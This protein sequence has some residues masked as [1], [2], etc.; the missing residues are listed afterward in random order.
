MKT[1]V[2]GKY[3]DI[4]EWPGVKAPNGYLWWPDY[5]EK[6]TFEQYPGL[7]DPGSGPGAPW[8][9]VPPPTSRPSRPGRRPGWPGP[10]SGA[11][12]RE[13]RPSCPTICSATPCS[14]PTAS[15]Y[16]ITAEKTAAAH[17]QNHERHPGGPRPASPYSLTWN[18]TGQECQ[19]W[20]LENLTALAFAIDRPGH[21]PC[22]LP[23][24]PGGGHCGKRLPWRPWRPSRWTMIP[25]PLPGGETA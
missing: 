5:L 6:D 9:A 17:R 8:S 21:Q 12:R 19:A 11:N 16:A 23:T 15:I 24:G 14:G 1:P 25:V 18:A 4:V 3:Q 20:T 13:Q 2:D 10:E 22:V 7:C